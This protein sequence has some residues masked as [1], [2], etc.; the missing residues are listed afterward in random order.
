MYV[1]MYARYQE[2]VFNALND[3]VLDRGPSP[4]LTAVEVYCN[5]RKI[6]LVQV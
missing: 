4:F 3:L 6:T 1:C 2:T 5:N